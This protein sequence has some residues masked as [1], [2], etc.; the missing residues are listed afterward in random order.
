MTVVLILSVMGALAQ[1]PADGSYLVRM[2]GAV[3]TVRA[4]VGTMVPVAEQAAGRLADGGKLYAAGQPSLVAEITGRAGGL[5]MIKPLAAAIPAPRDVVLFA[6]ERGMDL[7]EPLRGTKAMVVVFGG[8]VAG[9]HDWPAFSNHAAE[10]GISPTLANAIPAWMFTGEIVGALTRIGKMPVVFETIGA[11]G[12]YARMAQYK[13]GEIA[14]HDDRNV[15]PCAA[16]ALANAYAEAV[17]G[18]LLR[19]EKEERTALD[20]AGEWVREA[21]N[22]KKQL[23]MYSMGHLFPD[24]V[25][26]TDIG[27]LFHSAGWNAGFRA[28]HP[29]DSYREGDLAVHIGYQHPTDALL[30]RARPAG[31]RVVYVSLF[32]DRDFAKDDGVIWIDPM[33]N[34][35]DACVPL[36]G[37]DV[38]LL[39]ASGIINGAVAWEIYRLGTEPR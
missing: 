23:F 11:Y 8:P 10:T 5:M 28:P 15:P 14:F 4:D 37:Y 21:R 13:S 6:P 38:P 39:P 30:R 25:G 31:A 33:W 35:P 2:A 1:T 3:E 24:E 16:G 34:W 29:E 32:A 20:R 36:E 9:G 22:G 17:T 18:M 26:N 7:P 19:I 12:G 27:R